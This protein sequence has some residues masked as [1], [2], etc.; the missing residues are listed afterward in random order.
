[1]SG[2]VDLATSKH[3]PDNPCV[4]IGDGNRGPVEATP[5]VKLV[6]PRIEWVCL[7]GRRAHDGAGT[8]HQQATEV[9]ASAFGGA[10]QHGPLAARMLTR[11]Q[12]NPG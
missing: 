10:E 9:L 7:S 5:L 6:D 1:M 2:V 12:A 4:L 3:G 11:D 8:M